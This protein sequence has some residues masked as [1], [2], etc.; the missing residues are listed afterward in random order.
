MRSSFSKASSPTTLRSLETRPDDLAFSAAAAHAG[1]LSPQGKILFEFFCVRTPE[2]FV[3]EV[4]RDQAGHLVKRLAMYKLRAAVRSR[5]F[6]IA[7]GCS[8]SGGRTLLVGSDDGHDRISGSPPP[9]P[10]NAHSGGSAV[11]GRYRFGDQRF[12]S[13]SRRISRPP[14]CA[15]RPGRWQGLRLW[16]RLS[17][18]SKFRSLRRCVFHEGMLR[19]PGDRRAHAAQDRR[20]KARRAG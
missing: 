3:L 16:R 1:L 7:I 15:W 12:Q 14:H 19:R 9:G 13:C 11:R 6:R 8:H 18:R 5:T 17:A 4:A 20:Q 2:G 10:R